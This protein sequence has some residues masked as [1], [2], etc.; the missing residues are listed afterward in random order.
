MGS[1]D[2][3]FADAD[4]SPSLAFSFGATQTPPIERLYTPNLAFSFGE[5]DYTP[6]LG[7]RFGTLDA[8]PVER[9]YTPSLDFSFP[10]NTGGTPPPPSRT[11]GQ[12]WPVSA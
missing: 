10:L 11:T 5:P 7:I 1:L 4:Y 6:S 8:E 9:L 12:L 3:I 2:F